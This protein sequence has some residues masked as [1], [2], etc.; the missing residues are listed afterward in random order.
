MKEVG[1]PK[2]LFKN[3]DLTPIQHILWT[4]L[5]TEG[6]SRPVQYTPEWDLHAL[7]IRQLEQIPYIKDL[8]KRLRRE[9]SLHVQGQVN[10]AVMDICRCSLQLPDQPLNS[11]HLQVQLI[12]K[13]RLPT[14]LTLSTVP[15]P[16]CLG[17]IS[18]GL[19][20]PGMPRVRGD[21]RRVLGHALL[22]L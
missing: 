18:A 21:E 20:S 8:V 16:P 5:H 4:K 22:D 3:L 1:S 13:N 10:P 15:A 9:R 19:V 14:L 7:M 17:L 11:I 2:L 12:P 6:P